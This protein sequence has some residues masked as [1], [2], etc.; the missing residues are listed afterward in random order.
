[1]TLDTAKKAIDWI[2]A[3]IPDDM[4]GIEI[5]FIGGEPLLEFELIKEIVEYT[6]SNKHKEGY[7]FYATTNGTTLD[8]EKKEWFTLH[9]NCF[10]LG[11]SL[12]GKRETHNYNRSCSFDAIDINFF[13]ENWPN[14]GIKMT[15]STY[16]LPRL[17]EDIKFIHSIGFKEISGV[18][19]FEGD[20]DWSKD[21]YIRVLIPQLTELVDFYVD[22]DTLTVNQMF[23]KSLSFCEVKNRSK[24]NW[25]GIGTGAVFIDIDGS[26][27]PCPL[28]TPMTFTDSE[29]SS[30]KKTDFTDVDKF[31]DNECFENCYIYPIC[32]TCVGANYLCNKTFNERDKR[33]CRVQKLISLFI[34]ELQ[35]KRIRKNPQIYDDN[36]LYHT[37]EAIK[38]VRSMYLAEFKSFFI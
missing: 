12:D 14:Q 25:C 26:I 9:K 33:R 21:E 3:N 11:L 18:N 19:L 20:F 2:F 36:T 16:S 31:I 32:P 5:G 1:M 8:E 6:Y 15:L 22:N 24:R 7:L 27:F 30:L 10:V 34:A 38:K 29:L 17:A 35:A 4:S 28:V 37:I 13:L 23:N